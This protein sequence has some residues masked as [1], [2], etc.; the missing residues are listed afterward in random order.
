LPYF[1]PEFFCIIATLGNKI[2][3]KVVWIFQGI[4]KVEI[5]DKR[6]KWYKVKDPGT[7]V[8]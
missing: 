5:L 3:Q 2:F 1:S 7:V 6:G 8:T 4:I